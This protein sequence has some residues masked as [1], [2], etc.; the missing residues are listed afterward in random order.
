MHD[1]VRVFVDDNTTAIHSSV[2][3][4]LFHGLS[5]YKGAQLVRYSISMA[6]SIICMLARILVPFF[7]DGNGIYKIVSNLGSFGTEGIQRKIGTSSM[8]LSVNRPVPNRKSA[9]GLQ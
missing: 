3:W 7:T 1:L 5:G 6:L 9:T 8:L 4:V 2:W